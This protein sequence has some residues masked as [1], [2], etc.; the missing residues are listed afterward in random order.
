MKRK[1]LIVLLFLTM[2]INGSVMA[3]NVKIETNVTTGSSGTSNTCTT[4]ICCGTYGVGVSGDY[5]DGIR[6][7]LLNSSNNS[8]IKRKDLWFTKAKA[9]AARA[10]ENDNIE[11]IYNSFKTAQNNNIYVEDVFYYAGFINYLDANKVEEI[12]RKLGYNLNSAKNYYIVIEPIFMLEYKYYSIVPHHTGNIAEISKKLYDGDGCGT[13]EVCKK[14]SRYY[15]YKD[16][17]DC[18]GKAGGGLSGSCQNWSVL[19]NYLTTF[20]LNETYG[21]YTDGSSKTY[22]ADMIDSYSTNKYGKGIIV[23]K[24]YIRTGNLTINKTKKDGT[25]I[26]GKDA[27][28]NIY[29]GDGC[30]NKNF[31]QEVTINGS[32]TIE[33]EVGNYSFKETVAPGSYKK[34]DECRNFTIKPGET[35]TKN[36]EN[37]STCESEFDELVGW[38][39]TDPQIRLGLF[40]KYLNRAEG[41]PYQLL[42]FN[43]VTNPCSATRDCGMVYNSTCT[44]TNIKYNGFNSNNLSCYSTLESV[45]N[46]NAYCVYEY[47]YNS[48]FLNAYNKNSFVNAGRIIFQDLDNLGTGY[49]QKRCY[50][51]DGSA[52]YSGGFNYTDYIDSVSILNQKLDYDVTNIEPINNDKEYIGRRNI[53]YSKIN[54]IEK[55]SGLSSDRYCIEGECIKVSGIVTRF[56]ND[57]NSSDNFNINFTPDVRVTGTYLDLLQKDNSDFSNKVNQSDY[58]SYTFDKQMI[59]DN[60]PNLEFRIIDTRNPFPGKTG[61]GRIIGSNWCDGEGTCTSVGIENYN[62]LTTI[63]NN[64]INR[65]NSN[66]ING[67]GDKVSPKYIIN[68]NYNSIKDIR[69]YNNNHDYSNFSQVCDSEQKCGSRFLS[70]IKNKNYIVTTN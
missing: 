66:G 24:E 43:N 41:A 57:I 70:E 20:M 68:L 2:F 21:K 37:E 69:E 5:N 49:L 42:N 64:I 51:Y 13:N 14:Y 56:E 1:L 3:A 54:Y 62:N 7:I 25:M 23:I 63:Q 4:G 29:T 59:K 47:N 60:K 12:L 50:S 30:E 52:D 61:E 27:K 18:I 17:E 6:V 15:Y 46:K 26:V 31:K 58:C 45:D 19:K 67:N 32:G 35:N 34:D 55:V 8:E 53:K 36:I 11:T 22:V 10:N 16:Y 28:F 9:K 39:R 33:L 65:T 48:A 38:Q 40:N 44:N